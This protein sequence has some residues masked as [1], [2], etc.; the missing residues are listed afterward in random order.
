MRR[1]SGITN[2][3]KK[4]YPSPRQ[5][6]GVPTQRH[7][8]LF[9]FQAGVVPIASNMRRG[10][11]VH[12]HVS[13]SVF[14]SPK[15][16]GGGGCQCVRLYGG[17]GNTPALATEQIS[18]RRCVS[19]AQQF[20]SDFDLEP[21]GAEVKICHR[22][23]PYGTSVDALFQRGEMVGV[24]MP[25]RPVVLVSWK[26]GQGPRNDFE[27]RQHQA[28]VAFEWA[29]LVGSHRIAVESAYIV[30][31][32]AARGTGS[33]RA[34]TGHYF[35]LAVD[36]STIG[37]L[38]GPLKTKMTGS[39]RAKKKRRSPPAKKVVKLT[40]VRKQRS[41]SAAAALARAKARKRKQ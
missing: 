36:A 30:Y 3:I 23:L 31:L 40:A 12:R 41:A 17:G 22:T 8:K 1:L 25:Q 13:H 15:K 38:Y 2:L 14:C 20:V 26:T 27:L 28:Q 29:T 33:N 21:V 11:L 18:V 32:T 24:P 10:E 5:T 16:S 4:C 7:L 34:V 9:N 37:G 39:G 6:R 19:A 35:P